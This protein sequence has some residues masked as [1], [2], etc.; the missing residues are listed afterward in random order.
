VENLVRAYRRCQEAEELSREQRQQQSRRV[1]FRHDDD[2]SL[3]LTCRLPAEAGALVMKALD[4]AVDGL[5]VY[6]DVPAGTSL[7]SPGQNACPALR[8]DRMMISLTST[9]SGCETM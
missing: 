6:T 7:P 8:I 1:S 4:V 3:V 9:S 5:P 2:G